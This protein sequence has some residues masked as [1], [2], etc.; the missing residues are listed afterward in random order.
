MNYILS[1]A[2]NSAL[3]GRQPRSG[4]MMACMITGAGTHLQIQTE[5]NLNIVVN[6][7]SLS[8]MLVHAY[9]AYPS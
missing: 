8:L 4:W 7:D 3:I 5:I 9:E 6:T 2:P 1:P